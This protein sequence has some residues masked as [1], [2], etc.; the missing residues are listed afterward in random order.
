MRFRVSLI[1]WRYR[2]CIWQLYQTE[3]LE[4]L[5]VL[6]PLDFDR[7]WHARSPQKFKFYWISSQRF[8]VFCLF[9]VINNIVWFWIGHLHKFFAKVPQS[10]FLGVPLFLS[11]T[12]TTSLMMLYLIF[13]SLL[14]ILLLS[15]LNLMRHLICSNNY[16][17]LLNLNLI[18]ETLC[19]WARFGFL[20]LML[21]KPYLFRLTGLISLVLLM[22]KWMYL[23]LR[24]YHLLRSCGCLSLLN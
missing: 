17:W 7:V 1:K 9:L 11:Y 12:L 19:T 22:W 10:V 8:G 16:S 6:E 2:I 18:Y 4:L 3:L 24:K 14:M 20:I 5:R 21:E 23:S 13:L 15:T